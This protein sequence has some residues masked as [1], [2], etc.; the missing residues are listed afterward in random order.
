MSFLCA[1]ICVL[2]IGNYMYYTYWYY[3]SGRPYMLSVYTCNYVSI[4]IYVSL[5]VYVFFYVCVWVCIYVYVCMCMFMYMYL[6]VYVY[7]YM[8]V[9]IFVCVYV[10]VCVWVCVCVS[11]YVY[12]C[13]S[14]PILHLNYINLIRWIITI[15]YRYVAYMCI[16]MH[17]YY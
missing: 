11:G 8:W 12:V 1:A 14:N 17:I 15:P 16:Y 13:I 5:Y 4:Y 6:Y 9:C 3:S 7:I 2:Y 10:C